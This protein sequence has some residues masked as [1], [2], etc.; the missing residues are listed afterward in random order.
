MLVCPFTII[1]HSQTVLV[2]CVFLSSWI[3]RDNTGSNVSRRMNSESK[4]CGRKRSWN[5]FSCSPDIWLLYSTFVVPSEIRTGLQEGTEIA[6]AVKEGTCRN[7]CAM[8]SLSNL[9]NHSFPCFTSSLFPLGL[10][11]Q[12]Y[13]QGISCFSVFCVYILEQIYRVTDNFMR[14]SLSRE[15]YIYAAISNNKSS[16][17]QS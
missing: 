11:A 4:K 13:V 12:I 2:R 16:S 14:K 15:I 5:N 1:V 8:R 6:A 17:T 10:S 7:C 3:N 9:L